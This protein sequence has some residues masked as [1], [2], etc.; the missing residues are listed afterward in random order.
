LAKVKLSQRN[1]HSIVAEFVHKRRDLRMVLVDRWFDNEHDVCCLVKNLSNFFQEDSSPTRW[2]I[3]DQV[4]KTEDLFARLDPYLLDIHQGSQHRVA[5]EFVRERPNL[6]LFPDQ[7]AIRLNLTLERQYGRRVTLGIKPS[8]LRQQDRIM[9]ARHIRTPSPLA[10]LS[11][12][13]LIHLGHIG[14]RTLHN[15]HSESFVAIEPR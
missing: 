5:T 4:T 14:D 9:S 6:R 8:Y 1:Q 7:P 15:A 11:L 13:T 2:R 10:V 12:E 3:P